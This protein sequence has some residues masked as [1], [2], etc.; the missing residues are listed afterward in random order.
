MKN[1][2]FWSIRKTR[3]ERSSVFHIIREFGLPKVKRGKIAFPKSI[4]PNIKFII[5][6][7]SLISWVLNCFH[8]TF[9][10]INGFI[11]MAITQI[12]LILLIS[13][14]TKKKEKLKIPKKH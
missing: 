9:Q 1:K 7:G 14:P 12:V 5:S 4:T 10:G 3:K 11:V 2:T 13:P 6:T 8:D